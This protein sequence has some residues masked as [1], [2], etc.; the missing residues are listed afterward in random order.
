MISKNIEESEFIWKPSAMLL[1]ISQQVVVYYF[2]RLFMLC[3][4]LN[5]LLRYENLLT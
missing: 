1:S 4:D 2:C 3:L 5:G